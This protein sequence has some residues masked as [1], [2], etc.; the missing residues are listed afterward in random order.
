MTLTASNAWE[1]KLYFDVPR[2][3]DYLH[4]PFD[5]PRI[6]Q[7]PEWFTVEKN[8]N[9]SVTVNGQ[10]SRYS[11]AELSKGLALSVAAGQTLVIEVM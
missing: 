1:G 10:K 3:R 2:H 7:Y 8:K 11:G 5:W 6:N 9:Y 4:L